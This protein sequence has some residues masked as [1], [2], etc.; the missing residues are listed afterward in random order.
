MSVVPKLYGGIMF[1]SLCIFLPLFC[2]SNQELN[3]DALCGCNSV[4]EPI[5]CQYAHLTYVVGREAA[6]EECVPATT[7]WQLWSQAS[8]AGQA[9]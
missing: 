4:E 6:T 2:L 1:K 3:F 9:S 5:D 8:V 7:I